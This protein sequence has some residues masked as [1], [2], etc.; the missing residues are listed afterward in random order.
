MSRSPRS[1][2]RCV[3]AR[4]NAGSHRGLPGQTHPTARLRTLRPRRRGRRP[5][6]A[7]LYSDD[8]AIF[9]D[10]QGI[11]ERLGLNIEFAR[12]ENFVPPLARSA[13]RHVFID[14]VGRVS[15]YHHDPYSQLLSKVVRGFNRDIQDAEN[16]L[17]SGMVDAERF[18]ALVLGIPERAF[19]K[20][21]TL[22][23]KAVLE[24]VDHFLARIED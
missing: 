5:H 11:K 15:F 3:P 9:R 17:A 8:E 22:S 23:R 6:D 2:G 21:P 14:T 12:P 18:R 10:L 7:D 20:Y 13:N 24:A 16:L 1:Q 19:A 4:S